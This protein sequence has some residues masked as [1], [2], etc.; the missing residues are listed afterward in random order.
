ML[1][2]WKMK[3][4]ELIEILL[5]PLEL[6]F[7]KERYERGWPS[8]SN[9]VDILHQ[10]AELS[11]AYGTIIEIEDGVGKVQIKRRKLRVE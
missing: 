11:E 7:G 2:V 8:V 3:N 6:G 9:D 4:G 10:L 1:P 5:Y